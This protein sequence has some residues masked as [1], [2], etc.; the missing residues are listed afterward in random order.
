ME[1]AV[2][3]DSISLFS[4][5]T[6]DVVLAI[7]AKLDSD[8]RHWARLACTSS[9]FASLIHNIC[10]KEKCTQMIDVSPGSGGWAALYRLNV[11][12]PGLDHAG[13]LLDNSDF[14]LELD[15]GPN[16]IVPR[17]KEETAAKEKDVAMET[18][19]ATVPSSDF[20]GWT[21]FDD[22]YNDAVYDLSES[23][24]GS[25]SAT[26]V[27]IKHKR[28]ADV[29]A[30]EDDIITNRKKKKA[31]PR[32]FGNTGPIYKIFSFKTPLYKFKITS[33]TISKIIK[34]E[35]VINII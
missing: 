23:E 24:M 26:E 7:L 10:C 6:D 29:S 14:G 2:V 33:Q 19:S 9:R 4:L 15:I 17:R 18:E 13:V 27:Y 16:H 5:L 8:P 11:C 12:C 32:S 30:S 20:Q 25:S 22:L 1:P 31:H 34:L 21:M 3:A 35:F 28:T